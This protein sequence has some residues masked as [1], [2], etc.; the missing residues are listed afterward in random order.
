[1]DAAREEEEEEEEEGFLPAR[2]RRRREPASGGRDIKSDDGEEAEVF[3]AGFHEGSPRSQVG[4]QKIPHPCL[5]S[6][7]PLQPRRPDRA[8]PT[9]SAP[10]SPATPWRLVFPSAA[11]IPHLRSRSD[12]TSVSFAFLRSPR[13]RAGDLCSPVVDSLP[14]GNHVFTRPSSSSGRP[15]RR[16]AGAD[17]FPISLPLQQTP[18]FAR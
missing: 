6:A 17:G 16:E 9:P 14:E 13:R 11:S 5:V 15:S 4:K 18:L 10:A 2:E 1:M 12:E 3:L 8:S 7:A